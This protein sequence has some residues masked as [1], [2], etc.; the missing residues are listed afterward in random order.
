MG[1]LGG[2]RRGLAAAAVA[3]AVVVLCPGAA[4]ANGDTTAT[5]S[6][7]TLYLAINVSHSS[8]CDGSVPGGWQC[9]PVAVVTASPFYSGSRTPLSGGFISFYGWA[10]CQIREKSDGFDNSWTSWRDCSPSSKSATGTRSWNSSQSPLG[11]QHVFEW[12]QEINVD[13][14]LAQDC[15][16]VRM[17]VYGSGYVQARLDNGS[18]LGTSPTT[19]VYYPSSTGWDYQT[20]C[21]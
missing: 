12:G 20:V 15:V 16:E 2:R 19:S 13:T 11:G 10:T 7:G 6:T 18:V 8:V 21:E 1:F 3:A 4:Y 5:T 17:R 9:T 14:W